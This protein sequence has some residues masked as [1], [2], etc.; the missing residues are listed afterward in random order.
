MR[1]DLLPDALWQEVERLLPPHPPSPK[2]GRPRVPDRACL[3]ALTYLLRE[4][5]TYRGLPCQELG[6]GSGVTVWRRLQEWN[7]AGVWEKLHEAL[8]RHLGMAGEIDTSIVVADSGSCRAVK[9]GPTPGPTPR[10]GGSKAVSA[11]YLRTPAA[12]R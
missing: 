7:Q 1:T 11:M 12:S 6:C 3:T 8:L 10:T 5:C 9:G 4:G 2:G